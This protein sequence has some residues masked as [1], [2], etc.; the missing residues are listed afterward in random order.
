VDGDVDWDDFLRIEP[1]IVGPDNGP[2]PAGGDV[3]DFNADL[4]VDLADFTLFQQ[5]FGL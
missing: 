3:F 4:D 5:S 1:S 2:P